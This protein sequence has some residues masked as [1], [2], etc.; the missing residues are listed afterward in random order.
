[1]KTLYGDI[2]LKKGQG[3]IVDLIYPAYAKAEIPSTN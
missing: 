1:M 3:S 2:P